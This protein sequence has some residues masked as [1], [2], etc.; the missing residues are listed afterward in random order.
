M[1]H[2]IPENQTP[3]LV[4]SKVLNQHIIGPAGSVGL[5]LEPIFRVMELMKVDKDDQMF[6]LD[7]VQKVHHAMIETYKDKQK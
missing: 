1:P 7:L 5:Q 6:C 2:L 3:Y 4:Y